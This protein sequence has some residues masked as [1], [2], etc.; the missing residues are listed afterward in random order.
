L[1][2]RI[3]SCLWKG[4]QSGISC[5][6]QPIK[7]QIHTSMQCVIDLDK[8]WGF[9]LSILYWLRVNLGCLSKLSLFLGIQI[10]FQFP[11]SASLLTFSLLWQCTFSFIVL[12]IKLGASCMLDKCPTTDHILP[13]CEKWLHLLSS[14][15]VSGTMPELSYAF[16]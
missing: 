7:M 11:H 4:P 12:G 14:Y 9:L 3:E 15:C 16:V 5:F 8:R 1:F 10:K 2:L 13:P 6:L